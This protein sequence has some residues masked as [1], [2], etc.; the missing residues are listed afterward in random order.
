MQ[1]G[2][3]WKSS[4]LVQARNRSGF[5]LIELLVVIAIIA[6]L[7]GILLPSLGSA[8]NTAR[9]VKCAASQR[10]VSQAVAIYQ[11][12]SRYFP[13]HYVY[14]DSTTGLSWR[15]QDQITSNPAAGNGYIHWSYSLFS[16]GAVA[17]DAFKCPSVFNGGAP[18][19]NP[20]AETKNWEEGQLNDLGGGP[21]S[22]T[23]DD[24]QVKRIAYAGNAAVFPRNKFVGSA[25][26]RL[27]KFVKDAD[28]EFASNT[29]MLT[30]YL[31][32][33]QWASLRVNGVIKSHRPITPFVGIGSGGDVYSQLNGSAAISPFRYN[34][35]QEIY[36]D[37]T[38]IPEGVIE[39]ADAP[40][41]AVGRHHPG[42]KGGKGGT[43]NFAFIDGHVE[44]STVFK[45]V[46]QRKWGQRFYSL[47]GSDI[48][49]QPPTP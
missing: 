28:I 19:T 39:D 16:D 36:P 20:G 30:E 40:I 8:R 47:T 6:L 32:R 38:T 49:V 29:I 41:N 37:D 33:P 34:T 25:G 23:P 18:A 45:T 17:E 21:G 46:E 35:E 31:A 10:S 22:A 14:G 43:T 13:A 15:I 26:Q 5:T 12:N 44:Q 9:T 48:R 3:V 2:R 42:L 27:N 24:R 4:S 11:T 1:N 7:I